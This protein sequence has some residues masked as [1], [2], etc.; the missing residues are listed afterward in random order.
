MSDTFEPRRV[1]VI[2]AAELHGLAGIVATNL[3]VDTGAVLT[4]LK[5]Q[6]LV[7]AGYDLAGARSRMRIATVSRME[8]V[9][10]LL[11]ETL[12]ALD[13]RRQSIA[14]LSH[15]LPLD[16]RLGG[17]LGLNFFRGQTLTVDF[18]TGA[19]RLE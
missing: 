12:T 4:M 19:V 7:A 5:P 6:L 14:V 13:H 1:L 2:V 3:L 9:P 17:V 11:I 10:L 15:Q 16:A 8:L 18:R